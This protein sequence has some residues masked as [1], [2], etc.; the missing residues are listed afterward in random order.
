MKRVPFLESRRGP[1]TKAEREHLKRL[2]DDARAASDTA[3]A[4]RR[5]VA[6]FTGRLRAKVE[7]A[8]RHGRLGDAARRSLRQQQRDD[9]AVR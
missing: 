6:Q 5:R 7:I 4:A 1:I 3:A 9:G 8:R 2:V